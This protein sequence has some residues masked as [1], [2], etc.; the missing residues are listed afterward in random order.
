[1]KYLEAILIE[2]LIDFFEKDY[3]RINHAISVLFEC[4]QIIKEKKHYDLDLLTACALLHDVGIKESEK[5][6]G[7]NNGKTQEQYGPDIAEK[8]LKK[9]KFPAHKIIIVKQIIANHHSPSIYDYTE[10]AI[11]KEADKKVNFI[12]EN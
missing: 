11:L 2:K 10:L 7:Y 1:M 12:K 5:V 9:I 8:I 4:K 3:K 6:L